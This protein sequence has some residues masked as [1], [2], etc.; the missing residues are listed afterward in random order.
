VVRKLVILHYRLARKLTVIGILASF[1]LVLA[2]SQAMANDENVTKLV[3]LFV[4]HHH[5]GRPVDPVVYRD[6]VACILSH[7]ME[8]VFRIQVH[9]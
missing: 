5:S 3:G 6:H 7:T 8:D 2:L 9:L 1:V 4:Y